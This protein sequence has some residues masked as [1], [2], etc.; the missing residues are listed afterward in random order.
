MYVYDTATVMT[1]PAAANTVHG[2]CFMF[3]SAASGR[4]REKEIDGPQFTH[5]EPSGVC[6]RV[7]QVQSFPLNLGSNKL[8]V[9][10]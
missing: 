4:E 6:R 10:L 8:K 5:S 2:C 1:L 9:V 3:L 7:V